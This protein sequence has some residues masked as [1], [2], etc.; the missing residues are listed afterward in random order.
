MQEKQAFEGNKGIIESK[1][2]PSAK[3]IQL[4]LI[5]AGYNPGKVDGRIGKQTIEAI[6]S[7]QKAHNLVADGK[8]GKK[9]W[10]VL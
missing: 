10:A 6:K 4:A 2:Q 9:T 3:D 1:S 8:V 5:N 7:F